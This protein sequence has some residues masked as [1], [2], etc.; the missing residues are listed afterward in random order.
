[1]KQKIFIYAILSFVS[2]FCCFTNVYGKAMEKKN[3]ELA[4]V[5]T[6]IQRSVLDTSI[7]AFV[8]NGMLIIQSSDKHLNIE[9]VIL[10]ASNQIVYERTVLAEDTGYISISLAQEY[11][12][13]KLT[14]LYGGCLYGMI[15]GN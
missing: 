8:E 15:S 10:D 2:L 6:E 3:I 4:G 5:W 7:R 11:N 13:L 9:V 1:M 12:I 14:N